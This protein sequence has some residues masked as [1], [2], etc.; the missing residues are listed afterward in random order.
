MQHDIRDMIFSVCI[1]IGVLLTSLA[2]WY[3]IIVVFF[4]LFSTT[5]DADKVKP[6]SIIEHT[7][8]E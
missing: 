2:L 7:V 3:A 6:V 4:K 8:K 5:V 1:V